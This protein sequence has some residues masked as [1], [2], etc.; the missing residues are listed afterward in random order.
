M[1][2]GISEEGV[3]RKL[4]QQMNSRIP[5]RRCWLS[6]LLTSEEPHYLGKDGSRFELDEQELRAVAKALAEIGERDVKLPILLIG[7]ASQSKSVWRV[8]GNIEC[9]LLSHI[10]GRQLGSDRE[11]MF[12]YAPHLMTLRRKLPTTTACIFLP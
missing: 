10:L 6:E 4:V 8:E 3:L 11:R 1:S 7:D 9:A 2:G 12:L 5:S